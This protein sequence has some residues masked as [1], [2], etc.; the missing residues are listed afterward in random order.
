MRHGPFAYF[1]DVL[2]LWLLFI[3]SALTIAGALEAGFRFGRARRSVRSGEPD[4]AMTTVVSA[5]LA[6]LGFM[7]AMTF[8]I[9][10]SRFD[11]R[12]Q[13]FLREVNAI[14]TAY[15]RVDL[16][17]QDLQPA[18]K[19][20]LKEYVDVRLRAVDEG[21]LAEGLARSLELHTLLWGLTV[22]AAREA[23]NPVVVALFV[24][25]ANQVIDVHADRIVAAFQSRLPPAVWLVLYL[26]A[27]VGMAEIG[28]QA[29]RAGSARSPAMVGLVISCAAVLWLV[30]CLDRPGEG[31]LRISQ[32]AMRELQV[33][34][35]T[36]GAGAG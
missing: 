27:V 2:P 16:L 25:A 24:Q 34:M 4:V 30:A 20:C 26:V 9:A 13:A 10:V 17:P 19:G 5:T 8:S 11:G 12:R 7:L 22:R 33:L 21:A 28:Y 29:A 18:A 32:Q 14:G 1:L 23:S 35:A 36:D 31:P 3:C 6:L 15:L